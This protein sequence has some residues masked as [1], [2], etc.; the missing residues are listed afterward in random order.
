M[1]RKEKLQLQTGLSG[2]FSE[3]ALD[4]KEGESLDKGMQSF[5]TRDSA[6]W[7]KAFAL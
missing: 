7:N 1:E 4:D 5:F 3:I 6:S 2:I